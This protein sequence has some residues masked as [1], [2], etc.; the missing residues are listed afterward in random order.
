MRFFLEKGNFQPGFSGYD[1]QSRCGDQDGQ[2]W[3]AAPSPTRCGLEVDLVGRRNAISMATSIQ[4]EDAQPVG[5]PGE[6]AESQEPCS[7][8]A[9]ECS[10]EQRRDGKKTREREPPGRTRL[11]VTAHGRQEG[12]RHQRE[13][14]RLAPQRRCGGADQWAPKNRN[15][16]DDEG[17]T[18][19]DEDPQQQ[20][21]EAEGEP[22]K[23]RRN[24]VLGGF[25]VVELDHVQT[26]ASSDDDDGNHGHRRS[27]VVIENTVGASS[28]S[29]VVFEIVAKPRISFEGAQIEAPVV[30]PGL[31]GDQSQGRVAVAHVIGRQRC[32]GEHGHAQ[33]K[34]DTRRGGLVSPRRHDPHRTAAAGQPLAHPGRRER[35]T[36]LISTVPSASG[37]SDWMMADATKETVQRIGRGRHLL[38]VVPTLDVSG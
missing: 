30:T 26:E 18:I 17:G 1:R 2:D 24:Q 20:V 35:V 22:A 37:E 36:A 15:Q 23:H 31:G 5:E 8:A 25:F 9:E 21:N 38:R 32:D 19:R 27:D 12:G 34:H 33:S 11:R 10:Q 3:E 16:G 14:D 7:R 29:V 6:H 28:H 4:A 13:S